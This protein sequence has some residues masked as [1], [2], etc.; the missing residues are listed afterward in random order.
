MEEIEREAREEAEAAAEE[1][2]EIVEEFVWLWGDK[3]RTQDVRLMHYH[4]LWMTPKMLELGKS[5]QGKQGR[6][7]RAGTK[8]RQA[9]GDTVIQPEPAEKGSAKAKMTATPCQARKRN[10]ADFR[11]SEQE[12]GRAC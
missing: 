3:M 8:I 7:E 12:R 9:V 1:E 4:G 11:S 10:S 5:F 2:G 6:G